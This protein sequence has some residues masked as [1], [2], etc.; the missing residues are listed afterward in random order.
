MRKSSKFL[1][2]FERE[3]TPKEILI[4]RRENDWQKQTKL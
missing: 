2:E 3:I 4:K 1:T